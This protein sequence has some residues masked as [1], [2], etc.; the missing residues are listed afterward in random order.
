MTVEEACTDRAAQDVS[1]ADVMRIATAFAEFF[2]GE[3]RGL[4]IAKVYEYCCT[5]LGESEEQVNELVDS[6]RA[7]LDEHSD[8][9]S[10]DMSKVGSPLEL[11]SQAMGQLSLLAVSASLPREEAPPL[12]SEVLEENGR[13]RK[14]VL[15]LTQSSMTDP[16]TSLFNRAYLMQHL[17]DRCNRAGDLRAH[18]GV[19]FVDVD[20]F[21]RVNDTYGHLV[22]DEVLRVMA[23]VLRDAVRETDVVTR[24]GG[25]EFVVLTSAADRTSLERQ[26]ERL[27]QRIEQQMINCG[28]VSLK[29][30][31]SIGGAI[32]VPDDCHPN[33][34]ARLLETADSAMY[35][36][37]RGGRN[38][39]TIL[40]QVAAG[41]CV[42]GAALQPA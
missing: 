2:S 30:T 22:G 7:E 29:V 42:A 37:K 17:Q 38:R 8:L 18:V 6:V 12:P 25:E 1:L 41:L 3:H 36:S 19:L 16:L 23:R 34:S 32:A 15:E 31:A 13:L 35:V 24:Y 9:F 5:I 21:K 11:L 40:D 26:A 20:H 4:A 33:F 27:R 28:E 10:V 39:V 14:R